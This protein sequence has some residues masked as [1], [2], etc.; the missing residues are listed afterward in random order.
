M[1][2]FRR[3]SEPAWQALSEAL[4]TYHWFKREFQ[5]M[6]RANFAEAPDALAAVNFDE[7]KRIAT[8]QLIRA[9]RLNEKKYQSVVIDAL[10]ALSEVDPEF[11]HLARLNDGATLVAEAKAAHE[12]VR[13]I[14]YQYSELA[15]S[16]EATRRQAEEMAARESARQLHETRLD[17][18]K[19]HFFELH[20]SDDEPHKRGYAFER[21][22]NALFELWDLNTRASY[23]IEHE[24]ID[25]AFTFRTDDYL[26]EARWRAEQ[27]KASD[28]SAFRIKVDGKARNTLGLCVSIAG[29]TQGAI[30]MHSRGQT[31]LILMDGIDLIP[32]LEG[33]IDLTEVLERKRRH[34]AETGNPMY[35]ASSLTTHES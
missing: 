12:A 13:A 14:T 26:L 5:T 22:L 3:L 33:R 35:R 32:I 21:L 4:R 29:F 2:A 6:V 11:T 27:T 31:P 9:L 24:Q 34:A 16:R 25:G 23:S 7:T 15:A 19:Q 8:D 17:Q 20:Q 28:L 10:V 30:S 1:P 18:L